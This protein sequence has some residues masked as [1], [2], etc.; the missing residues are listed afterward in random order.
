MIQL[1]VDDDANRDALAEL[2]EARYDVTTDRNELTGDLLLVDDR[3]FSRYR[4][5]ITELKDDAPSSFRPVVLV[6]RPETRLDP[7][8]LEERSDGG[9]PL[10]DDVVGAP[11]QQVVLFRRLSNLLV[12]RKQFEQ[13]EA[14]N[15]RLEEFASVVTHDLR[16]PLQVAKGR[17][18]LLEPSVSA[19]DREQLEI[20][21]ESL[22]RMESIVDTVLAQ[23]RNGL[24]TDRS[25][26]HLRSV[27][28]DAWSVIEAPDA[29][30][31]EPDGESV[32]VA[33]PDHLLTAFENLFRN[34]VEHAGDDVT[35]DVGVLESGVYIADDGPGID[36]SDRENV[37]ERGYSGTGGGT[38]L[39]LDIVANAVEAHGWELT[40]TE[41]DAGGARFEITG[42]ERPD[43]DR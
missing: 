27:V 30:L 40:I 38:G 31:I 14:Q 16:N 15:E 42:V 39:G 3:S 6:R 17:L 22:D 37:L 13:L 9:N 26:L 5:R 20:V 8:L 23:A 21:A 33:D 10:V 25:E 28:R 43:P 4:D 1:L 36:P 2:L 18:D 29:S 7:S 34:A 24:T 11:V 41:S 19:A 35:I 12:R 32:V